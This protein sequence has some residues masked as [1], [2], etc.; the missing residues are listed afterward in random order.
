MKVCSFLPSAT[1]V[2]FALGLG[3]NL[4]GVTNEC[5][6]P[7]EARGKPVVVQ[8]LLDPSAMGQGEI[9]ARVVSDISHGHGIYRINRDLLFREKPDVVITQELCDVCSVSLR[10]VLKTVSELSTRCRVVSL[11]PH[12][13][14]GVFDDILEIG[15]A[16][17]AGSRA[18]ALV[19][20]LR[21]R[22]GVV[23]DASR[24][25]PRKRVFCVEW[26]DPLFAPGHWIPEMVEIAGGTEVVGRAHEDSRR[27]A[28][29]E[30]VEKDPE[31][32]VLMPC[33]FSVERA[34]SDLGLLQRLKGWE[35]VSA[36]RDGNVYATDGSSF[37]SRPGPRLVDGL[38]I[39]A[40]AIHPEA[41]G[42]SADPDRLLRAGTL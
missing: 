33:G 10:E 35:D 19:S 37:F 28:W 6:Y 29:E 2:V 3:E 13:L 34:V 20:E 12:G 18:Q 14:E 26:Y 7:P 9:D 25:L 36:V 16:C 22:A 32:I 38:E 4:C 41:F 8:S 21:G 40:R 1:E 27:V 5:D 23:R 11:A 24:S 39:L 30:V 15:D 17:G 31:V 42:E